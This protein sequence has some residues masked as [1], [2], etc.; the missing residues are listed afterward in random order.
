MAFPQFKNIAMMERMKITWG[1]ETE[2]EF[3]NSADPKLSEAFMR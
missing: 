2:G 1:T 3:I